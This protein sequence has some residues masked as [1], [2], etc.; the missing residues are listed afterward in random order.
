[1]YPDRNLKCKK[2]P[3]WLLGERFMLIGTKETFFVTEEIFQF[4]KRI[5]NHFEEQFYQKTFFLNPHLATNWT[6]E[7]YERSA[8]SKALKGVWDWDVGGA[9]GRD[10]RWK[11]AAGIWIGTSEKDPSGNPLDEFYR[12]QLMHCH[13]DQSIH[14][15]MARQ[16]HDTSGAN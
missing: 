11:V 8:K 13:R 15:E 10:N 12:V 6:D 2:R 4:K 9:Q 5:C 16:M 14:I 1:M 7:K 3:K